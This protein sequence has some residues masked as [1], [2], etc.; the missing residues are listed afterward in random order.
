MSPLARKSQLD[1]P[2]CA[3]SIHL[4]NYKANAFAKQPFQLE[5]GS[6]SA[7]VVYA[8]VLV[9]WYIGLGWRMEPVGRPWLRALK[10]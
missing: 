1:H 7:K 8:P 2:I 6:H 9:H 10:A 3:D 4:S 5:R